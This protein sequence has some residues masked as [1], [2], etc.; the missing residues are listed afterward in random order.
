MRVLGTRV[1]RKRRN[2]ERNLQQNEKKNPLVI[3]FITE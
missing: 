3:Y 1:F 2:E